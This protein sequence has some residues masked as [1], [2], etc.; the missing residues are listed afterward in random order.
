MHFVNPQSLFA[1]M[2]ALAGGQVHTQDA[3]TL[4][5]VTKPLENAIV[6]YQDPSP[7]QNSSTDGMSTALTRVIPQ[8]ALEW[9]R[10]GWVPL[11]EQELMHSILIQGE[12]QSFL[13]MNKKRC[14][15]EIKMATQTRQEDMET[16][17]ESDHEMS[18]PTIKSPGHVQMPMKVNAVKNETKGKSYQSDVDDFFNNL[19][20]TAKPVARQPVIQNYYQQNKRGN[21]DVEKNSIPEKKRRMDM[22][23]TTPIRTV[24]SVPASVPAVAND[25]PFLSAESESQKGKYFIKKQVKK[26]TRIIHLKPYTPLIVC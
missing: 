26:N 15:N 24:P 11:E 9:V 21:E 1:S 6:V 20:N 23:E 13:V 19:K 2:V 18:V 16:E 25:Q 10:H 4:L 7:P 14:E 3:S 8:E 17:S 5:P 22:Q 12:F